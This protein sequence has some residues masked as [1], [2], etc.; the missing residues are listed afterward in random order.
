MPPLPPLKR[1][2]IAMDRGSLDW[3][4]LPLEVVM[5]FIA[6]MTALIAGALLLPALAGVIPYY[7]NGL[8]GL[9]LFYFALQTVLMGK[10]PFGDLPPS[11]ALL[12][13]GT[14]I[15]AAG[16]VICIIPSVPPGLA[17]RLLFIFLVPGGAALLVQAVF[18]PA[19]IRLW[20]GLG[21]A[22]KP[23]ILWAP[24]V[25]LA[26]IATGSVFFLGGGEPGWRLL[27]ALLF[28]GAAVLGL[29]RTLAAVYRVYPASRPESEGRAPVPFGQGMLLLTGVFMVLL[30]LL[31]IPV[32]LGLLPFAQ[33]AQLGLLMAIFAVQTAAAG[34][35]PVG[36]FPRSAATTFAGLAF[37]ALGAASC[38]IPAFLDGFLVPLVGVLNITGGAITLAK[39]ALSL[40]GARKAVAGG[41]SLLLK[42]L[43][44]TQAVLG[45]LSVMFGSSM[46]FPGIVP[47][48]VTGTVLAANGG[49]LIFLMALLRRVEALAGQIAENRPPEGV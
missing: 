20:K 40:P 22:V 1:R 46:L 38:V 18:S 35:T 45:V 49:A 17:G 41:A 3:G 32:N 2:R 25:Y 11:G 26:S 14:A 9:T 6:G 44:G 34:N 7:G 23:L 28:Q 43:Y 29:G 8:A 30:G 37:G 24:A 27:P 36:P 31:L 19:K 42:K 15:A 21:G 39:S 48:L 33:S 4:E 12:A 10:T 5:L 16:I 47:G 13:A